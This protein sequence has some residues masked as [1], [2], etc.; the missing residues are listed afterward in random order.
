MSIL[1]LFCGKV[2]LLWC[3]VYYTLST[4]WIIG[5]SK[6]S[7]FPVEFTDQPFPSWIFL[8]GSTHYEWLYKETF[9]L[10]HRTKKLLVMCTSVGSYLIMIKRYLDTPLQRCL[11]H[12]LRLHATSYLF[13]N[14]KCIYMRIHVFVGRLV[15][16]VK[17]NASYIHTLSV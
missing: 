1:S 4:Y 7:E 6:I 10:V 3:T 13:V 9:M 17:L 2:T 12:L 5:S 11:T 16:F 15:N 14:V 8:L